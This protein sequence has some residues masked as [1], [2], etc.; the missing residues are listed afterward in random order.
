MRLRLE[1]IDG[2]QAAVKEGARLEAEI[3]AQEVKTRA[4]HEAYLKQDTKLRELSDNR[5]HIQDREASLCTALVF[6]GEG[7]LNTLLLKTDQ[8]IQEKCVEIAHLEG[9]ISRGRYDPDRAWKP[10]L[11]RAPSDLSKAQS[12]KRKL[13]AAASTART[14][15]NARISPREQVA[16]VEALEASLAQE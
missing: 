1:A 8:V 12:M 16:R 3:A 4:A 15:V 9:V 5:R 14:W 2:I 10:A 13:E 6:L 7:P 11:V